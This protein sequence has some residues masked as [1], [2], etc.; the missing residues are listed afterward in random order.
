MPDHFHLLAKAPD[1]TGEIKATAAI[2]V[3]ANSRC[4]GAGLFGH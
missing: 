2:E 1:V 4:L 3:W